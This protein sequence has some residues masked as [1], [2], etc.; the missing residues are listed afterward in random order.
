MT[1]KIEEQKEQDV[2]YASISKKS[3]VR[4]P[5]WCDVFLDLDFLFVDHPDKT[6]SRGRSSSSA[7]VA[8]VFTTLPVAGP[9]P[10]TIVSSLM[11]IVIIL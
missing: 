2:S 1:E 5:A 10:C 4:P 8:L 9:K 6:H 7:I 3:F 11:L